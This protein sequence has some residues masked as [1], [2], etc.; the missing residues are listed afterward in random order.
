[1][2][3]NPSLYLAVGI[4][5]ILAIGSLFVAQESSGADP[6]ET[7]VIERDGIVY[8]LDPGYGY[9]R[10]AAVMGVADG[11]DSSDIEI[12]STVTHEGHDY[13]VRSIADDAFRD[14]TGLVSVELPQSMTGIGDGAFAGCTSLVDINI[15]YMVTELRETFVGCTSLESIMLTGTSATTPLRA[16]FFS[17]RS[18]CPEWRR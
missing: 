6:S 1:M 5:A 11:F 12:P 15:P 4:I 2:G 9:N 18:T 8:E 17:R 14:Q 10:S 16:A 13:R 7:L 3:R